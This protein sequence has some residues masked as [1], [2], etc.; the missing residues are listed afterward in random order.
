METNLSK[1]GKISFPKWVVELNY[2]SITLWSKL[3]NNIIPVRS[4]D[5]CSDNLPLGLVG[6]CTEENSND[7]IDP[8]QAP[9]QIL[10]GG[11][12][13]QKST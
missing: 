12:A 1:W 4:Y 7:W 5:K 3:I 8:K 9:P 13:N 6:G 11:Y 2:S 10:R